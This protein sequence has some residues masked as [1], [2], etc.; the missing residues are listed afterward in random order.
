MK[1]NKRREIL[2]GIAIFIIFFLVAVFLIRRHQDAVITVESPLPTSVSLYQQQLQNNFGITVPDN[3]KKADLKDV[4]GANQMG[5]ATL[6]NQNGKFVYTVI[7]NLEDP[8][9]GYFYQAWIVN[10]KDNVSLGQLSV[11]K[12]GWITN[13]TSSKDLSDHKTIWITLE[14]ANDNIPEM[15]ILEGSF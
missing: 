13:F 12:G 2:T 8:T 14:R 9:P 3:A 15:H 1:Q 11:E 4:S 7:A 6:E 10:G 5:L